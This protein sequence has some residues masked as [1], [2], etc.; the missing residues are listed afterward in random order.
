[1]YS[2]A[3]IVNPYLNS[4]RL[5]P[6]KS[7]NSFNHNPSKSDLFSSLKQHDFSTLFDLTDFQFVIN[8]DKCR[9][10]EGVNTE[11]DTDPEGQISF[12]F[13]LIF[14]HSAPDH[15][16]KRD[17]IRTTWGNVR[18]LNA[19]NMRIVFLVGQIDDSRSR[20]QRELEDE[21]Q[22]FHDII[23]GNFIDDYRNLTYKHIMGLKWAIYYCRNAKYVLKTDDDIFV[24][25]IQLKYYLKARFGNGSPHVHAR[26]LMLCHLIT[27]PNPKR[28]YRSKWRVSFQVCHIRMYTCIHVHMYITISFK[29]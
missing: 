18:N 22:R 1:M 4:F 24:D 12:P 14:I 11:L 21:N 7:F 8:N 20:L 16:L 19:L 26:K 6:I 13:L 3:N 17:V 28:S 25:I 27:N 9:L 29:L 2:R 5:P 23:Q 10:N 15:I